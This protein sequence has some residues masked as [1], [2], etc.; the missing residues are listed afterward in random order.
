M[1]LLI[2]MYCL[3][4]ICISTVF[5]RSLMTTVLFI[6]MT[7][8]L[9]L[10]YFSVFMPEEKKSGPYCQCPSCM[11]LTPQSHIHCNVCGTCV[12]VLYK[13]WVVSD[14]CTNK[15]NI[16]RYVTL[17]K[18]I[19]VTNIFVCVVHLYFYP[20]ILLLIAVHLFALKSTYTRLQKDI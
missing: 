3:F 11:K 15:E 19:I 12:P 4:S 8:L 20:P 14:T 2:S 6:M 18:I 5:E 10:F 7:I 16:M 1:H 9:Q 13:H 17:L